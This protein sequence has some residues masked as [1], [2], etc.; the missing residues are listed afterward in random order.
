MEASGERA[1]AA[2]RDI[3]QVATGDFVTQIGRAT[4]L[5]AEALTLGAASGPVR[6][7]PG[8]TA[9]FV[10]RERELALLDE[11]FEA[12]GGVVVHAVHG[13]GGVGKSTL[14][15]QW[16]ATRVA[17]LNPVWW[18][19]AESPAQLDA[20]L[21][22]LGRALQPTLAGTLP[23]A[24]LRERTLQW[25]ST[26][27]GWLLVLDNVTDPA[28]IRPL[29]ARAANGRFLVTTRR[30]ATSWRGLARTLDL[31]VLPLGE[32]VELFTRVYEGAS[33]GVEELC[34]ELG[35]LPLA[36]DQ[37]AAYCREA[38]IT[39]G[40]YLDLLARYPAALYAAGPEGGDAERTIARI[41]RVT[42]NRLTDTPLAERVL[43]IIAWWAPEGIPRRYLEMPGR[44]SLEITEAIR[45]LAAHS[46]ITLRDGTLSVHRLVQAVARTPQPTDG[47][48]M[49]DM[50]GVYRR[51]AVMLLGMEEDR[52]SQGPDGNDL[53]GLLGAE[54]RVWATHV[55]ALAAWYPRNE[56]TEETAELFV[57]AGSQ[58]GVHGFTRRAMVLCERA[59]DAALHAC[60][61]DDELT[62][63]ARRQLGQICSLHGDFERARELLTQVLDDCE[64]L[65]GPEH[66]DTIQARDELAMTLENADRRRSFLA[67]LDAQ[68]AEP[69]L[70]GTRPDTSA[71]TNPD[72]RSAGAS[73]PAR[74]DV[75]GA[76]S[77]P[78]PVDPEDAMELIELAFQASDDG[79][80][81]RAV[82]LIGNAVT[83]SRR[84]FGDASGITILARAIQVML[85]RKAGDHERADELAAGVSDDSSR[86]LG[87]AEIA[88]IVRLG[89]AGL[90]PDKPS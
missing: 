87:D 63:F 15:A 65:L 41:W 25:L 26:H 43:R 71:P 42:L 61:P 55:E 24:A 32:A 48:L 81:E 82:T 85:L 2:G 88:R 66:E 49:G 47:P 12:P 54:G 64:R 20:G 70:G 62:W 6:Y 83:Q 18:I 33:D 69:V 28:D 77:E 53:G 56:D 79:E 40:A 9:Q 80:T 50:I 10:G 58:L 89:V 30:S 57:T 78:G 11:A 23:D 19:T 68:G 72:D 27:D 45:R 51:M 84:A 59:V 21:A 36:I 13:L 39:P 46:V 22:D 8:R 67:R 14:A 38:G 60:G 5:P 1:V 37:A 7:L 73:R 3:G 34:A 52:W 17:D 75:D 16:A 4:V 31:D 44:N 74:L 35:C 76:A 90:T 29:L 86:V